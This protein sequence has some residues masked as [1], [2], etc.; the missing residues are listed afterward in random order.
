MAA[1]ISASLIVSIDL[2]EQ[3]QNLLTHLS[4]E[5][6]EGSVQ[7]QSLNS[8]HLS[9]PQQLLAFNIHL[10]PVTV[11]PILKGRIY[12]KKSWSGEYEMKKYAVL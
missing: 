2:L 7:S 11:L 1:Q 3:A 9:E 12:L 8:F 10:W 6:P 4:F 5:V